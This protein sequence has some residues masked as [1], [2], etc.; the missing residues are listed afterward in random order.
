MATA[1]NAPVRS[2]PTLAEL[3]RAFFGVALMG[4]GGVMPWARRMLVEKRKWM[5]DVEFGEALALAQF[6]PGG[7]IVNLAVAVGQRYHG[8]P[9]ALAAC[10]GL[11][12]GPIVIVTTLTTLFLRYGQGEPV[13]AALGGVAAGAAGL[14]LSMAGKLA[15]PLVGRREAAPTVIALAAFL[16]VGPAGLPL[17]PVILVLA[18]LSIAHAWWRLR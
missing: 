6:L 1:D 17:V 18:P 15:R 8:A 7:N 3:F 11:L 5:D 16:A 9:G 12:V 2:I 10:A 13:K 14:M 4:F